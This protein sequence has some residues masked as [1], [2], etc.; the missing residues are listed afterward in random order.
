MDWTR[1]SRDYTALVH[2]NIVIRN[3]RNNAWNVAAAARIL[4]PANVHQAAVVEKP[5]WDGS[6]V[7]KC[8]R[9]LRERKEH[10]GEKPKELYEHNRHPSLKRPFHSR[11]SGNICIKSCR[12]LANPTIGLPKKPSDQGIDRQVLLLV[13]VLVLVLLLVLAAAR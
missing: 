8:L 1:A 6:E 10:I 2:D 3:H 12:Q 7:Q 9:E 4:A 5:R 13:L 11:R